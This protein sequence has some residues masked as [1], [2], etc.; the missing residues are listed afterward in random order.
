M[1]E[2]KKIIEE[3]VKFKT[4]SITCNKCW[5]KETWKMAELWMNWYS[6]FNVMFGYG[7]KH[8]W[9][10]WSFDLCDDCLENIIKNFK[11]KPSSIDNYKFL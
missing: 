6:E 7:S 2:V 4:I 11:Y 3:K 5:N 8:D 1:K 9:D 10:T